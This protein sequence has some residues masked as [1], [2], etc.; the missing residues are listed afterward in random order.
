MLR[1]EMGFTPCRGDPDVWMRPAR[2]ANG[3]RYYEY[4][5]V[6]V[7]DILAI[8]EDPKAILD[9]LDSHFLLKADSIGEPSTYLGATIS[10]HMLDGDDRYTWAIGPV[11]YLKEALRV[12]KQRIEPLGLKLKTKV[13]NQMPSNYRP[14]L[15]S[16]EYLVDDAALLYMQFIGILRWLV[17]LG[18]VDVCTEVSMMSAYNAMPRMGHL[19]AVL[20]I[21]AYL[22]HHID[23]RLV[24]DASYN[25]HLPQ[26]QKHD[27]KEFYP[28]AHD[29]I[30]TDT[31]EPL[32]QQ[33]ELV[34][35]V[36]ASHA[37]NLVTRQSR[38][39]VLIYVN[40]APIIWYS[41]KQNSVE[42]SSF[43]SEAQAL[44]TGV[45]LLEGLRYKLRMM[46]VPMSGY[47]HTC[48]DNMS[49]V[50]NASIPES[51][52][53]KKS[54]SIA[55]HY[56]RSKSAADIIRVAYENTKTNIADMLTKVHSG[57]IRQRLV[58]M[59]MYPGDY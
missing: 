49:V 53:K 29:E 28:W 45:E 55:Y 8:S 35:F 1:E 18:R 44:K 48:V 51:T 27:W 5:L 16:T 24:L 56:V 32:G 15:D 39:G 36:D 40:K 52:L 20:H 37:A 54:N 17:E 41:K 57:P 46:G 11:K 34:M 12:V 4:L 10:K 23:R 22:Q 9:V 30:P 21:F 3:E 7:D 33:V 6:Y 38:T 25:S 58:D 50:N 42:T 26:L 19:H 31:P 47:C 43:G 59:V 14:E 2:K 13:T